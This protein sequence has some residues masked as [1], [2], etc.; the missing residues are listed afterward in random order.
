M[1]EENYTSGS[2][3]HPMDNEQ[4]IGNE[5]YDSSNNIGTSTSTHIAEKVLPKGVSV[6]V[7]PILLNDAEPDLIKEHGI[8]GI[9]GIKDTKRVLFRRVAGN[10]KEGS[11]YPISLCDLLLQFSD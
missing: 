9:P 1:S 5:T 2:D 6:S 7:S 11:T 3:R 10:G 4:E 8:P